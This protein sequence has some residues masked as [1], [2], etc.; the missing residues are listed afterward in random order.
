MADRTR[1]AAGRLVRWH[2]TRN[3]WSQSE[4]GRRLGTSQPAV[5]QVESGH[6]GQALLAL[7]LF[8][9]GAPGAGELIAA[10]PRSMH[11]RR[12]AARAWRR[13]Q[14]ARPQRLRTFDLPPAIAALAQR[15]RA[16]S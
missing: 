12:A 16:A 3:G 1:E 14:R 15:K 9:V 13:S 2:R 10:E 8:I 6:A 5:S 4:L 7:A 11:A